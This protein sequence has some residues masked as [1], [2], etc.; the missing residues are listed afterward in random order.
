MR[1]LAELDSLGVPDLAPH[2]VDGPG[3]GLT[4]TCLDSSVIGESERILAVEVLV[5]VRRPISIGVGTFGL[6]GSGGVF[7]RVQQDIEE[8]C[9]QCEM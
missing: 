6:S 3:T 7:D 8:D 9:P 4:F 1:Q 5:D 2:T